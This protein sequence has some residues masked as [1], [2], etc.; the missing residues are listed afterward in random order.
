VAYNVPHSGC[1]VL[2]WLQRVAQLT[3]CHAACRV[4]CQV[5]GT[6]AVPRRIGI[7]QLSPTA[8]PV[9]EEVPQRRTQVLHGTMYLA[10]RD[11]DVDE[12]VAQLDLDATDQPLPD[13]C[14]GVL[15]RVTLHASKHDMRTHTR[16]RTRA[17]VHA[18]ADA[19]ARAD[20]R[21]CR[22][23]RASARM[24]KHTHAHTQTLISTSA[25]SLLIS[26][27]CWCACRCGLR[28]LKATVVTSQAQMLRHSPWQ[29]ASSAVACTTG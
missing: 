7:G 2:Q 26:S 8:R 16:V 25:A 14:R 19:H 4:A 15:S 20:T 12:R 18:R 10:Q 5:Y 17:I 11:E 6:C 22:H 24:H 3:A 1:N 27:F 28:L 13:T 21:T 23:K 9:G 29:P